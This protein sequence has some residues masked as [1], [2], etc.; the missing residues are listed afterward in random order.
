[1]TNFNNRTT[2]NTST[3]PGRWPIPQENPMTSTPRFMRPLLLGAVVLAL[4]T[5]G[6]GCSWFKHRSNYAKSAETSPL[7]V[8]PDL[9]L[10]DTSTSTPI[11]STP[12]MA[13]AP[14]SS[15]TD[16]RLAMPASDAY[17]KIGDVLTAIDGVV[18]NGR[19]EA[20]GSYDVT[21]Q[22]QS[23]LIRV[24]DA[25]G[26]S[27]LVALSADGKMLNSGPAAQLMAAIKAKL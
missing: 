19:A 4:A 20:L 27:R 7:E 21:Y 23:F 1:M 5:A 22:G 2:V 26:G 25:N 14:A 18:I 8:P 10:P 12:G 17:P 3:P 9:D 13:S 6:S 15:G 11:P 24:L 16:G